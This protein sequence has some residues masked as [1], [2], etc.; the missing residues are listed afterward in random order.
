MDNLEYIKRILTD[1][2]WKATVV[3]F[4]KHV[5]IEFLNSLTHLHKSAETKKSWNKV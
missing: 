3:N 1:F 2:N 5:I 4:F